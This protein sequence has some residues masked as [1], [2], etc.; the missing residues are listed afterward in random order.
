MNGNETVER[1]R[2]VLVLGTMALALGLISFAAWRHS[3]WTMAAWS[4]ALINAI[5]L[6][7]VIVQKDG[8]IGRLWLFGMVA[9]I[10]EL[11]SDHFS[12]AVEGVLMLSLIH[13]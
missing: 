4:A 13:I 10:A 7:Y 8:L 6:G 11:P 2:W 1:K 12:V 9:G 3:G 5:I